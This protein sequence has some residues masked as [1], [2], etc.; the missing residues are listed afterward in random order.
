MKIALQPC[1]FCGVIPETVIEVENFW[2][3][4][5]FY[6]IC[7]NELCPMDRVYTRDHNDRETAA[8]AWNTRFTGKPESSA[9]L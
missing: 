8:R 6:V 9:V 3:S 1:P 2:T 5:K 7:L 4:N